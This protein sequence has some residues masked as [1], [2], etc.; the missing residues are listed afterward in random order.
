MR[1]I[2]RSEDAQ[3]LLTRAELRE[4]EKAQTEAD[5]VARSEEHIEAW[6]K[7][8]PRTDAPMHRPS[9]RAQAWARG[10]GTRY[11]VAMCAFGLVLMGAGYLYGKGVYDVGEAILLGGGGLFAR[12][13]MALETGG[14]IV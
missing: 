14:T 2:E 13:L 10:P 7:R 3:R 1:I 5:W 4:L 11:W 12:I 8:H 6:A 9:A